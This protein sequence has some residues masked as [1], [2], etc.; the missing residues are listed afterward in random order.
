M[1]PDWPS[2]SAVQLAPVLNLHNPRNYTPG[3]IPISEITRD[4]EMVDLR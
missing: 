1:A 2:P 4:F 3:Y